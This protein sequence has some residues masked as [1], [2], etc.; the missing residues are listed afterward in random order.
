VAAVL[1]ALF[2]ELVASHYRLRHL[3]KVSIV[4]LPVL[5][6]F[7]LAAMASFLDYYLSQY[8]LLNEVITVLNIKVTM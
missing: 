7:K 3:L 2:H 6:M 8:K 4:D 1:R 5:I